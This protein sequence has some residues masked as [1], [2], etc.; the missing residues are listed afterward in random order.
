M[1]Y[2]PIPLGTFIIFMHHDLWAFHASTYCL[3]HFFINGYIRS[4]RFIKFVKVSLLGTIHDTLPRVLS[5]KL[6]FEAFRSP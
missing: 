4:T 1:K 2:I 5:S 3:L 6:I